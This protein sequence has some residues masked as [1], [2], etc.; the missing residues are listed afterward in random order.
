M[1]S[2][3]ALENLMR[4]DK[5][6]IDNRISR[7]A[8]AEFRWRG[9]DAAVESVRIKTSTGLTR[10]NVSHFDFFESAKIRRTKRFERW[11]QCV[12]IANHNLVPDR[13]KRMLVAKPIQGWRNNYVIR[14]RDTISVLVIKPSATHAIQQA[15]NSFTHAS[16][17]IRWGTSHIMGMDEKISQS[18][19]FLKN[20][21]ESRR[22]CV[23][24]ILNLMWIDLPVLNLL[25][26]LNVSLVL[27]LRWK[28][29]AVSFVLL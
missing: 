3:P 9:M 12:R 27:L 24:D 22:Y 15:G 26:K 13:E 10:R 11:K 1:W 2:T 25:T 19:P 17:V 4:I 14:R 16:Y 20:E 5:W 18:I 6:M 8:R 29:P 28:L 21:S 7:L 23:F